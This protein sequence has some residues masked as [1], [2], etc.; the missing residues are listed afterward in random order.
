MTGLRAALVV[1][2]LT[3]REVSRRR[4]VLAL[5]IL[6]PLAFY[7]RFTLDQFFGD[8]PLSEL[9]GQQVDYLSAHGVTLSQNGGNAVIAFGTGSV[10]FLGLGLGDVHTSWIECSEFGLV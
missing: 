4:T 6:L 10:E 3:L 5:L 2:G 1:S 9:T 8:V 7:L